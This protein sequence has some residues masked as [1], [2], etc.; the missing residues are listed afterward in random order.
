[1]LFRTI[2]ILSL[3]C[4]FLAAPPLAAQPASEPLVGE[5]GVR[6]MFDRGDR[7]DAFRELDRIIE[8]RL[9]P[10]GARRDPVIDRLLGEAVSG[11]TPRIARDLLVRA[12]ESPTTRDRARYQLL[13]AR[14]HERLAD[15]ARAQVAYR[16][17][18]EQS[19][20]LAQRTAATVGL[21]RMLLI[22]RPS[23]ALELAAAQ[24]A[25]EDGGSNW[26]A[27][28][29]A[30][31]AAR[32][33][34]R[35]AEA[36]QYLETASR[37]AWS[38]PFVDAAVARVALD[39]AVIAGRAGD[40]QTLIALTA[41]TQDSAT[42][43][44][45]V[46]SR[47]LPECGVAGVEA[48]DFV[49]IELVN[50]FGERPV[51]GLIFASRPE[52]AAP[53][54]EAFGRTPPISPEDR[55]TSVLLRCSVT[56]PSDFGGF[57]APHEIIFGWATSI[58]AYPAI[59]MSDSQ[60][61]A[62]IAARLAEREARLGRDS[63]YLI[64][65]LAH[66]ILVSGEALV[67]DPGGARER[68]FGYADRLNALLIAHRA[69]ADARLMAALMKIFLEVAL[70]RKSQEQA[71]AEMHALVSAAAGDASTQ[72]ENL[73]AVG[74]GQ[75]Q[76]PNMSRELEAATLARILDATA[77]NESDPRRRGMAL[78]LA[79]LRQDLGDPAA[80]QALLSAHRLSADLCEVAETRLRFLS[81]DIRA[82]DYPDDSNAANLHGGV[83]LQLSVNG[84]G[85]PEDTRIV[86]AHP[87]YVFDAVTL[88]RAPTIRFEPA[89]A[90]GQ[91]V[92][93]RGVM[94]PLRWQLGFFR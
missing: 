52:A 70:E 9:R 79:R 4:A 21:S 55:A 38:A 30:G 67:T 28:L 32:M 86:A 60:D 77:A 7:S 81:S 44:N 51:A 71:V 43:L 69:P 49:V 58:G 1:M 39:R 47:T 5:D 93:C 46:L 35:D 88:A 27:A 18:L 26:E 2:A 8:T 75:S 37:R 61:F 57:T 84:A 72:P 41:L 36:A 87:P 25:R 91:A 53:F 68:I 89:R 34:G 56:P 50:G 66:L 12:L 40:R 92:S 14:T 19:P 17:V 13:L 76:L 78:R 54:I 11:V 31:R 62:G 48:D 80:A 22:G 24:S 10:A 16:D 82:E 59:G 45:T 3:G 73:F 63:P 83:T 94:Q 85:R 33:L 23:E 90:R 6:D 65:V 64:P 20:T 15:V 42:N 74:A 29:I